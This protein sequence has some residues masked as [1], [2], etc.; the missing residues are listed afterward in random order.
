MTR[1]EAEELEV[2]VETGKRAIRRN[3]PTTAGGTPEDI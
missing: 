3:P 2:A 1:Q